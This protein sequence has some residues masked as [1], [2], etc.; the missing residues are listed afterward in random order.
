[1]AKKTKLVLG[2]M[3]FLLA[4]VI[5]GIVYACIIEGPFEVGLDYYSGIPAI[6]IG[7]P[8]GFVLDSSQQV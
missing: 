2:S 8:I 5:G 1:M 6:V 3:A 4:G 7:R